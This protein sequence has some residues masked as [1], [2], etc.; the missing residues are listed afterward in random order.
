MSLGHED[1][2]QQLTHLRFVFDYQDAHRFLI[3]RARGQSRQQPQ[4]V[5][6][7]IHMQ[8]TSTSNGRPARSWPLRA[9]TR[10]SRPIGGALVHHL[11]TESMPDMIHRVGLTIATAAA[12]A[13]LV[14]A[15]AAAGFAP[16]AAPASAGTAADAS[17]AT[18]GVADTTAA[19]SASTDAA[20]SS[21]KVEIVYDN[22]YIPA[23]GT[24]Q[25]A[26]PPRAAAATPAPAA[27]DPAP[28]IIVRVAGGG[29]DNGG[30]SEGGDD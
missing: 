22:V 20:S 27:A 21:P 2:P 11:P 30:E 12:G 13:T 9:K 7:H 6:L 1:T 10:S 5:S 8:G 16:L 17:S 24:P 19:P 18:P 14:I 28:E 4:G 29:D 15:V 26:D 23:A 3:V 25:P